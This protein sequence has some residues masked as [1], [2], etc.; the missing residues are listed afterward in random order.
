MPCTNLTAALI[1]DRASADLGELALAG[2]NR[3]PWFRSGRTGRVRY[4]LDDLAAFVE[5][6]RRDE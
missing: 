6:Q 2:Q 1:V 4:R 5:A 3:L